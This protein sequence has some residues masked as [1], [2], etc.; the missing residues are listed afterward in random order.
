MPKNIQIWPEI[1]IFVHFGLGLAG[2]FGALLVGWLVAFSTMIMISIDGSPIKLDIL[3]A[4]HADVPHAQFDL[5]LCNLN[6][7][8]NTNYL[9]LTY[10][11]W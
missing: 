11:T 7:D 6:F 9:E 8:H 3:D 5:E 4:N 10:M 1:G 2:S